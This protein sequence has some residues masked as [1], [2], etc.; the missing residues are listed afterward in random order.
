MIC[1][2]NSVISSIEYYV[3]SYSYYVRWYGYVVWWYVLW[4]DMV[5]DI[6]ASG[7]GCKVWEYEEMGI[8]GNG[9]GIRIKIYLV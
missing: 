1:D 7:N 9:N 5:W 8:S 3:C 4:R 2:M 6:I